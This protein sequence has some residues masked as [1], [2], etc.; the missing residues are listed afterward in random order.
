MVYDS[1]LRDPNSPMY[2]IFAGCRTQCRYHIYTWTPAGLQK[3]NGF[4]WAVLQ[5]VGV[6]S[7]FVSD[8]GGW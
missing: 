1:G 8:G 3:V 5:G 2:A 4:K 6:V 7:L